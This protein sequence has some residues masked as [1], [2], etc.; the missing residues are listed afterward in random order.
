MP[1]ED[2]SCLLLRG[3]CCKIMHLKG[4]IVAVVPSP[5]QWQA[6]GSSQEALQRIK[7]LW[8]ILAVYGRPRAAPRPP[9][10]SGWG[11]RKVCVRVLV[12]SRSRFCA[13][14]PKE[15]SC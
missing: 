14:A 13:P 9:C 15:N 11:R 12:A 1:S 7:Y 6:R 5:E 3:V 10:F 2:Q 8:H 4:A